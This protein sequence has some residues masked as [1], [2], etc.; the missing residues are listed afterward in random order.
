MAHN[1]FIEDSREKLLRSRVSH[2]LQTEFEKW[3]FNEAAQGR[4]SRQYDFAHFLNISPSTLT[5]IFVGKR[6][7]SFDTAFAICDKLGWSLD[8]FTGRTNIMNNLEFNE[9]DVA[10]QTVF[11]TTGVSLDELK[12][13]RKI[14]EKPI[15]KIDLKWIIYYLRGIYDC[16]WLGDKETQSGEWYM[17]YISCVEDLLDMFDKDFERPFEVKE[18][19][20]ETMG[21][22]WHRG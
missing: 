2:R 20:G 22:I 19:N 8:Y 7:L 16:D 14:F 11:E 17:G 1:N 13:Y 5:Q 18:E 6:R 12:A 9:Y 4:S 15:D 21:T 10:S 3:R